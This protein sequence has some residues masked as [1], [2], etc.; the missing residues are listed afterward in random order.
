MV[1]VFVRR[2]TET[3]MV[4]GLQYK[5]H[6]LGLCLPI[7]QHINQFVTLKDTKLKS[8]MSNRGSGAQHCSY[9]HPWSRVRVSP[10]LRVSFMFAG[11][12]PQVN[13]IRLDSNWSL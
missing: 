13:N 10:A 2:V 9:T 12:L 3:L 4:T 6:A 5:S 1:V 7:M 11:Y 8:H